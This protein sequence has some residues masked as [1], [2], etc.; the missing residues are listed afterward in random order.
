MTQFATAAELATRLGVSFNAT[1]TTD[2]NLL[3]TLASSVIASEAGQEIAL[4]EDDTLTRA[5]FAGSRLR[6]PQRP[7]V[8]VTS[9]T[10]NGV[11]LPGSD[12]ILDGDELI[13][14]TFW[15]PGSS[16]GSSMYDTIVV[17]YDHGYA[18]I[19]GIAKM[20]CLELAVRAWVNPGAVA[21]EGY[22]SENINYGPNL[23]MLLS[24]DERKMLRD[25]FRRGGGAG[26]VTLR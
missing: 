18:E 2:A 15:G 14:G 11:L 23:G 6:L 17:T 9:V 7:V 13:L 26:T 25:K 20:L 12:Y 16:W 8:S 3:L 5:G 22:G 1:E 10:V 19:P 4:V 21:G 24:Q